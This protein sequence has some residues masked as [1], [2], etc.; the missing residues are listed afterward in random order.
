MS[1]QMTSVSFQYRQ[2]AADAGR[3]AMD[4]A[5]DAEMFRLLQQALSWIQLAENEEMMAQAQPLSGS[6]AN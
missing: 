5:D 4:S 1:A 3:Q 6:A 2:R